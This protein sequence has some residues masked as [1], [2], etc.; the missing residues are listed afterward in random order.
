VESFYVVLALVAYIVIGCL[1]SQYARRS[2]GH[3]FVD[4]FLANRALGGII[5]ALTYAA[6][7]YSAFMM[8]GLVGFTYAFGVGTVGFE[9][10]YLVGALMILVLLGPRMWEVG[11]KRGYVTPAELLSDV[12]GNSLIGALFTVVCLAVLVPYMSVQMMGVGYL[13]EGMSGGEV[14]FEV[15]AL[16]AASVAIAWSLWAGLRSVAWTDALQAL[17]MIVTSL[18]LLF[19]VFYVWFGDFTRFTE[20]LASEHPELLRVPGSGWPFEKFLGLTLPWFFFALTNPQVS[21]RMFV[22]RGRSEFKSMVL[23]HAVF[24]LIYTVIV[25]LIGLAV[26]LIVPGLMKPDQAMPSLLALVPVPLALLVFVGIV[27][28]AITT[29]DS[30]LLTLSSMTARDLYGKTFKKR[31]EELELLVGKTTIVI[32]ACASF[33]FSLFRPGL[34]VE[35][36]VASSACLVS[37]APA[38]IDALTIKRG[39]SLSAGLSIAIGSGTAICL[40]LLGMRPLGQWPGVWGLIVSTV[41]F[42]GLSSVKSRRLLR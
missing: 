12:Y 38:L 29:V 7:T 34:I 42:V 35:L 16:I 33:I 39:N 22:P 9:L 1:L 6:T 28:A 2:M 21:Q 20:M 3:G 11:R 19:F 31:R 15:G 5:S 17:I 13:V 24:G 40:H 37:A 23:G 4:Y 8:V 30:I 36:S 26:R 10:V 32:V 18:I 27:S 25:T 14:P 41:L